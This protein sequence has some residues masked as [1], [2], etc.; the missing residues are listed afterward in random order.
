MQQCLLKTH[1]KTNAY[2]ITI[3]S[4]ALREEL[5]LFVGNNT[6]KKYEKQNL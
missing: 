1:M 3:F 6:G 5:T 2:S 4:A